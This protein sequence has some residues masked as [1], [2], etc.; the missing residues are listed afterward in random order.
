MAVHPAQQVAAP[1]VVVAAPEDSTPTEE[2]PEAIG[3]RRTPPDEDNVLREHVKTSK[4]ASMTGCSG[5]NQSDVFTKTTEKLA[6]YVGSNYK[7]GSV[8]A[9]AIETLK[10]PVVDEP[11]PQWKLWNNVVAA[12]V[13]I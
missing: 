11:A 12:L 3:T 1:Q 7:D 2:D 8:M 4:G 5:Y 10:T 13:W 9:T 6:I